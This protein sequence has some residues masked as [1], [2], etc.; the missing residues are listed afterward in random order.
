VF[1][2]GPFGKGCIL[3]FHPRFPLIWVPTIGIPR[4][5]ENRTHRREGGSPCEIR[6]IGWKTLLNGYLQS[7]MVALFENHRSGEL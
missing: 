6:C 1:R 4:T 5:D 3:V 7:N 2:L